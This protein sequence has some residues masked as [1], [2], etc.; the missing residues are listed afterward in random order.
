MSS[1][2]YSSA[3]RMISRE[4]VRLQ[5]IADNLANCNM[6]GFKKT[7]VASQTFDTLLSEQLDFYENMKG[8]GRFDPVSVDHAAGALQLTERALDFAINGDGYF[9]IQKDGKEFLTRNGQFHINAQGEMLTADG[10]KVMGLNGPI[11]INPEV[12]HEKMLVGKNGA[13][14]VGQEDLDVLRVVAVAEPDKLN[15]VGTTL[16]TAP[17]GTKP[18][19][20]SP[21]TEVINGYLETSNTTLYEEMAEM[22]SCLRS[23]EANS[24]VLKNHD[25]NVMAMIRQL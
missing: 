11:V 20:V 23:Y 3:F 13:L 9:V 18:Q 16:F 19:A 12:R 25:D 22:I 7:Q 2:F 24:K 6:P 15:R 4:E 10:S 8:R 5:A 21:G 1:G 17:E 14:S